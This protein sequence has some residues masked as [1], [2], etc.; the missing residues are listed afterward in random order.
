MSLLEL[1]VGDKRFRDTQKLL[2]YGTCVPDRYP[3]I[4]KEFTEGRTPVHVCLEAF[5]MD[6]VGYK[7][8]NIIKYSK[9]EELIILTI[10]GSPHCYQLH[11]LG[12]DIKRHFT[13]EGKV[14]ISH[15]VI[16]KGEIHEITYQTITV[17]RHL[18]RVQKLLDEKS[19]ASS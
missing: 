5:H 12:Q 3:A 11:A 2:L 19:N 18:H 13:S 14:K 16:E 6:H 15:F 10:D 17:A 7:L 4:L 1:N 9:I 8:V